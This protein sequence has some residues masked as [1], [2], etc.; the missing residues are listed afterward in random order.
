MSKKLGFALGAGGS[1]GVAHIGFLKAMEEKGIVP[2]YIS[3]CSMG[4]V[5]G[6]CYALGMSPDQMMEEINKLKFSDIFDLSLNPFGNGA[7]LRAKK[8]YKKLQSYLNDTTFNQ[9]KRPFTCVATDLNSGSIKTFSGDTK[10]VDAV[11]ASSSIP[12]IFKAVNID[13][14]SLVDGG[15]KC[16]VPIE[17]VRDMG[18]EVVIAVDVLG[19]V[20]ETERKFNMLSVIFRVYDIMDA[21]MS[22]KRA[23][24]HMPDLYIEPD[25]GDMV[26]YKFKDMEKAFEIGYQ[27]GL[28]NVDKIKVLIK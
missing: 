2:D 23:D 7:L 27:T 13:N 24:E 5:V 12:G 1:R 10:V 6:S 22:S 18:A 28:D 8:M 16:R 21:E 3:G 15:V 25:L 20:K 9:L 17:Q 14:M 26:Q 11:V 4:S 19:K